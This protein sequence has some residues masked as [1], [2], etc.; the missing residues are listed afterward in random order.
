MNKAR[1]T[2]ISAGLLLL[3]SCGVPTISG[4]PAGR[5]SGTETV[6]GIVT[7]GTISE[8]MSASTSNDLTISAN[9]LPISGTGVEFSEGAVIST[10]LDL[11]SGLGNFTTIL[12][13]NEIVRTPNGVIVVGMIDGG[14][15]GLDLSGSFENAYV[16]S[17]P[18]ALEARLASE[19][20]TV[21]DGQFVGFAVETIG[22]YRRQPG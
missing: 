8:S 13:V 7:V 14:G 1:L 20:I 2:T 17:A 15:A 16:L 18:D 4:I 11:G 10:T 6:T 22:N 19:I 3:G 21:I 5:Y 9:G 12:T